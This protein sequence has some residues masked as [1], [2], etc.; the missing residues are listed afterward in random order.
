MSANKPITQKE[1]IDSVGILRGFALFGILLI[2][3]TA[4]KSPG[5]PP[6]LEFEG[7]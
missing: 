3:I 2:N 4:F 5:T 7:A 6:G 1:R